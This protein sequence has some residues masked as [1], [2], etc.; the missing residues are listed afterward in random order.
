MTTWTAWKSVF[1][2]FCICV[3]KSLHIYVHRVRFWLIV[4]WLVGFFFNPLASRTVIPSVYRN[5]WEKLR[6]GLLSPFTLTYID[7]PLQKS[8]KRR[9][10]PKVVLKVKLVSVITVPFVS[11]IWKKKWIL[12]WFGKKQISPDRLQQYL[13]LMPVQQ[14]LSKDTVCFH[15]LHFSYSEFQLEKH[16][17]E[18]M[19][20]F[21]QRQR[22]LRICYLPALNSFHFCKA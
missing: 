21:L 6:D 12:H 15:R 1:I 19:T 20:T 13:S 9:S 14:T 10:G 4:G 7:V 18:S 5:I 2:H 16:L 22:G 3:F 17:R 8:P 11:S